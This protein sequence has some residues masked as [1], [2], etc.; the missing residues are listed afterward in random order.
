MHTHACMHASRVTDT[1]QYN[2]EYNAIQYN[3]IVILPTSSHKLR[4][5]HYNMSVSMTNMYCMS[6][7]YGYEKMLSAAH[8]HKRLYD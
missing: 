7:D 6:M 5:L 3:D 4:P 8:K 2:S 1:I